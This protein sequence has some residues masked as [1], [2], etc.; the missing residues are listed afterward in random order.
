MVEQPAFTNLQIH[1]RI[2]AAVTQL[3]FTTPTPIWA[4]AT[5]RTPLFRGDRPIMWIEVGQVLSKRG[6]GFG[7][8]RVTGEESGYTAGCST[9]G[10]AVKT[11][12]IGALSKHAAVAVITILGSIRADLLS[13]RCFF[14]SA[15]RHTQRVV[16]TRLLA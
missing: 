8:N 16:G 15:F 10:P 1:R 7:G 3:G 11:I 6:R 14:A 9:V 4:T 13:S 12:R 5:V 2:I